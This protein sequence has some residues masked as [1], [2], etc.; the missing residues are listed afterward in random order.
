MQS[1]K[2][3]LIP[4]GDFIEFFATSF[5][6]REKKKKSVLLCYLFLREKV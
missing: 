3:M 1:A 4:H 2:E 5:A 6:V